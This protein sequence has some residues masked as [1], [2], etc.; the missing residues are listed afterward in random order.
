[1]AW[2][3][4]RSVIMRWRMSWYSFYSRSVGRAGRIR[5]NLM[6]INPRRLLSR[7]K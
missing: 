3:F 6:L 1:M 2:L 5:D 7:K 4:P